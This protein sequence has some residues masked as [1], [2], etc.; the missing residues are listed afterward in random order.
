MFYSW[1]YAG[2]NSLLT[3]CFVVGLPRIA[4]SGGILD[5]D[6]QGKQALSSA[7]RFLVGGG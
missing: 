7:L 4:K 1:L 6:C 5:L 3:Q 2:T